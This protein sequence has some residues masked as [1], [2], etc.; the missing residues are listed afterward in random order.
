MAS[1]DW[2][3][4]SA[5]SETALLFFYVSKPP[6]MLSRME[7]TT[8]LR[9]QHGSD[10]TLC[11]TG[12]LKLIGQLPNHCE[13]SR[14]RWKA[15]VC[16]ISRLRVRSNHIVGLRNDHETPTHGKVGG[17]SNLRHDSRCTDCVGL[18]ILPRNVWDRCPSVVSLSFH[19]QIG[20]WPFAS[21]IR[22]PPMTVASSRVEPCRAMSSED[23]HSHSPDRSATA[24]AT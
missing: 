10:M 22:C 20:G 6:L 1:F 16:I 17:C 14:S 2:F 18:R 19:A 3:G 9:S 11:S 21:L 24:T 8:R 15:S 4:G 12:N 23:I 13:E 7:M 5:R